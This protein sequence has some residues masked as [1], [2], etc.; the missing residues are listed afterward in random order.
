M[1]NRNSISRMYSQ[2]T[3]SDESVKRCLECT[4]KQNTVRFPVKRILLAAACITLIMAI[5]IP[6]VGAS[7]HF[8]PYKALD[9][10][11]K[12][13]PYPE[14]QSSDNTLLYN[15]S[16]SAEGEVT[17]ARAQGLEITACESYFD[18]SM[19]CLSFA[20]EYSGEYENAFRFDYTDTQAEEFIV[21]GESVMP[22]YSASFFLLKTDDKFSGVL[23]LPCDSKKD[24]I[25][26][27]ICI[28]Y[29]EVSDEES[30]LG[31]LDGEFNFSLTIPRSDED[32]LTYTGMEISDDV[33]IQE[34][35][36]SP[37][38]FKLVCFVPDSKYSEGANI[39]ALITDE[40]GEYIRIIEGMNIETE[41][42]TR[43]ILRC[44]ATTASLVNVTL[45]DKNNTDGC[46]RE[47]CVVA[48]FSDIVLE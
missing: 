4:Q 10:Y 3:A 17:S 40:N 34:I 12:T 30:V 1:I 6:I 43:K 45:Y 26:V 42:G 48:E 33:Y 8:S 46:D 11:S 23:R 20:G 44:E 18:G 15:S 16:S 27:N 13:L 31:I 28:P 39:Q 47:L 14:K 5:M 9:E 41:S 36:S 25:D 7:E 37:A 21:D 38:G 2:I 22:L 19:V 24:E 29:L 35:A 32:V